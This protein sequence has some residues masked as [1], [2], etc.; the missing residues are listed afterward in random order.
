MSASLPLSRPHSVADVPAGGRHVRITADAG[1]RAA[2]A[3]A[4]ELPSVGALTAEFE[5]RRRGRA[6]LSVTGHVEAEVEQI[7]VVS[8]DPFPAT[9]RE[10]VEV[11]FVPPDHPG[12]RKPAAAVDAEAEEAATDLDAP[13]L[14]IDGR[15]DLGA[16]AVE[17]VALGLDPHPRKPGAA[18]VGPAIDDPGAETHPFAR[19]ARLRGDSGPEKG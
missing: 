15:I 4:L 19:L 5:L 7:C 17:F 12:R 1:E 9:V 14:L 6:G 18:F 11:E 16:L 3:A 10:P 13:D 8:L 2:V